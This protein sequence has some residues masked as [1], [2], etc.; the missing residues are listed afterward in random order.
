MKLKYIVFKNEQAIMFGEDW[1][2]FDFARFL[3]ARSAGFVSINSETRE[4]TCFGKSI[5]LGV[6]SM[7]EADKR[8]IERILN[9]LF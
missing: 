9:P 6:E 7:P 2:H 1:A 5:S 8:I 4:A 3:D